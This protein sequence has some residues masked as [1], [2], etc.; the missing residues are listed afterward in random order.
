MQSKRDELIEFVHICGQE[1]IPQHLV[2]RILRFGRQ[3]TTAAVHDCNVGLTEKQQKR[4]L[5]AGMRLNDALKEIGATASWSG[6]PR[7]CVVKLRVKSGRT[8]DMGQE[9]ICV[10]A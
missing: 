3:A 4:L 8:N 2:H 9:G 5:N 1:N 10:P 7:G 6:D